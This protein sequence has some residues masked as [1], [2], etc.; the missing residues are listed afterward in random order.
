MK[1]KVIKASEWGD[2]VIPDSI[3]RTLNLKPKDNVLIKK[4]IQIER[5][6]KEGLIG[7]EWEAIEKKLKIKCNLN[8][9]ALKC[10]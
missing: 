6:L 9:T 2:I 3:T 4:Y 1:T 7:V 10:Q 8:L 5:L